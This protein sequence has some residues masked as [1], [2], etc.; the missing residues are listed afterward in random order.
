MRDSKGRVTKRTLKDIVNS[1]TTFA[2][3]G[4]AGEDGLCNTQPYV[5]ESMKT[6]L[7]PDKSGDNISRTIR[8]TPS[9]Y[10]SNFLRDDSFGATGVLEIYDTNTRGNE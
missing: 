9:Q 3:G 1:I 4:I 8:A 2:G 10:F 6:A 5:L 7:N